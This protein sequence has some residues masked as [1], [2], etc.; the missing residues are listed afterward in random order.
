MKNL[1]GRLRLTIFV[2]AM[3]ALAVPT[4]GQSTVAN[5][6][7]NGGEGP[8]IGAVDWTTN[9]VSESTTPNNGNNGEFFNVTIGT[10]GDDLVTLDS[11]PVTI[12]SLTLGASSGSATLDIGSVM[13]DTLTIGDPTAP[14]GGA[15]ASL[16]VNSTGELNVFAG[17]KLNLNIA[18]GNGTVTNNGTINMD[19]TSGTGSSLLINDA[20]NT[21][22]LTLTGSGTLTL[23]PGSAI[24][25]VSGDETMI[26]N[27]T[28]QGSGSFSNL[29]LTNNG[30]MTANGSGGTLTIVPNASGFTNAG[31]VIVSSASDLVLDTSQ[32]A[33]GAP[34]LNFGTIA[35]NDGGIM[36]VVGIAGKTVSLA[37]VAEFGGVGAIDIG[38]AGVGGVLLLDGLNST[39]DLND[40]GFTTDGTPVPGTLTLSNNAGN[41]ITGITDTE[42]LINGT[43]ETLSGAGTIENLALVNN[44]TIIANGTNALNIV[45]NASGFTNTGTAD[46]HSG[47][48]LVLNTTAATNA[49]NNGLTNSGL[50]NVADGG[51]LQFKDS[52]TSLNRVGLI[53]NGAIDLGAAGAGGMI[54]LDGAKSV[55]N[56]MGTGSVFL[57]S[58]ANN[59]ITG[60]T[61]AENLLSQETIDGS[62][63]ISNLSLFAEGTLIA[64]AGAPL[65]IKPNVNSV[66][67]SFFSAGSYGFVSVAVQVAPGG[68][69][70]L[71]TTAS[72]AASLGPLVNAGTTTVNDGGT[73]EVI[74]TA[75]ETVSLVNVAGAFEG[76]GA[77][78]IGGGGVGGVLE[79]DGSKS[80]FDLNDAGFATEGV[81]MPGTLTL[82]NN[83]G[84]LITGVTGTETLINDVGETLSG[85]GT[86]EN[87]AL[88]NKGTIIANGTN[89][90]N[91]NTVATGSKAGFTNSGTIDVE[92]GSTLRATL[93]NGASG[94]GLANSGT[95]TVAKGGTFFVGLANTVTG[96]GLSNSGTMNVNDGSTLEFQNL[97]H[98]TTAT[99]NN[100]Q[101][102]IN[103]GQST[104]ATLL[105]NDSRN[106]TTFNLIATKGT[107]AG[108]TVTLVNSTIKG[109]S[110]DETLVNG[111]GN[112][113]EGSGTISNLALVNKGTI[114]ASGT[115]PLDLIP[116]NSGFTNDGTVNIEGS[117]LAV[118]GSVTNAGTIQTI[119]GDPASKF[120]V[121]GTF[122]NDVNGTLILA[123]S[124][125]SAIFGKLVNG[126]TIDAVKGAFVGIGDP[127][128][129]ITSG[130]QQLAD[131]TMDELI[132]SPTDF[133]IMKMSGPAAPG[134]TLEVTLEDGFIPKVGEQFAFMD[135]TPGDLKGAFS[136]FAGQTFDNGLEK[137][138]ISYNNAD[139][140]ILLTAEAN[141]TTPTPEPGSLVLLGTGL[142]GLGL[143][144]R[145][146]PGLGVR[147]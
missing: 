145:R 61:G 34:V 9:G 106:A 74:G 140:D 118:T 22:Q 28:I 5:S 47:S 39:F 107:S 124:G 40:G 32:A 121:S 15:A 101:G 79:F 104:G 105:L 30:T 17:S 51:I 21:H 94:T 80:T 60:V 6:V 66:G 138:G 128:F 77:I 89:A 139:G 46:V 20:G 120:T 3:M 71:N 99:I 27:I 1:N 19:A 57:S 130:C 49:G 98:G 91:I 102:N 147:R 42:T 48:A 58:N 23:Q 133:G 114:T 35:V 53:N 2:L 69:L 73:M 122:T 90:L 4:F 16:T 55:F 38:G 132:S 93:T 113:I 29:G 25:G 75:G 18:A 81:P 68:E 126:G 95:I 125:D 131:A 146:R 65:V 142:V 13:A 117:T 52:S 56:L 41:L 123:N 44:G 72:Q 88:V 50:I 84:N 54:Q 43:G 7:W 134:G 33:S 92:S 87:L 112:T 100:F 11:V 76:V 115:N 85:A 141:S 64:N 59:K 137:W 109:V 143:W 83:A 31:T 111:A 119:K 14:N 108:G 37:N 62:G 63:T 45:P 103:L 70:V 26:N 8:W 144:L 78:H 86:I 24:Q 129:T 12:D 82:S 110:G 36:G 96:T 136:D 135:F 97:N 67:I 116:N 127:N 10:G